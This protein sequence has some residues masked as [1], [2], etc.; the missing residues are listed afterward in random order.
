MAGFAI[1]STA[2]D[3]QRLHSEGNIERAGGIDVREMVRFGDRPLDLVVD[4]RTDR[5]LWFF[6]A[7]RQTTATRTGYFVGE[8]QADGD[9]LFR[10]FAQRL[11]SLH[12][13]GEWTFPRT[14][15]PE[16]K[17]GFE[18]GQL[19]A[20][21]PG[22]AGDDHAQFYTRLEREVA[23]AAE[24]IEIGMG[25][26]PSALQV[27][28]AIA[29]ADIDCTVAVA[30]HGEVTALDG[31]DVLLRPGG[32][33]DFEPHSEAA[34]EI[35]GG[36]A[37]ASSR[38]SGIASGAGGPGS[39]QIRSRNTRTVGLGGL[40]V[41]SVLALAVIAI[42]RPALRAP[43]LVLLTVGGGG[44]VI[45]LTYGVGPDRFTYREET[46]AGLI[47]VMGI[48]VYLG[49]IWTL[50][51]GGAR[52]SLVP[53][54]TLLGAGGAVVIVGADRLAR[55][56]H[57]LGSLLVAGLVVCVLASGVYAM[58]HLLGHISA[59]AAAT[60]ITSALLG[61]IAS[62]GL[63][64]AGR[65]ATTGA[66]TV[67]PGFGATDTRPDGRHRIGAGLIAVAAIG[68]YLAGVAVLLRR[69][70]RVELL[71][72][73]SILGIGGLV[74]VVG[75]DAL[76]RT[77]RAIAAALLGGL[78]LGVLGSSGLV[79]FHLSGHITAGVLA[80]RLV[81]AQLG[82]AACLGSYAALRLGLAGPRAVGSGLRP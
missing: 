31:I 59:G 80:T 11:Q 82:F 5:V 40:V 30:S 23:R 24:P 54:S 37:V 77:R 14:D 78:A 61:L 32:E 29:E 79:L 53:L 44:A 48:G 19:P 58:L 10:D 34:V 74:L 15:E 21:L 72:A 9:D 41:A 75:A 50:V 12:A 6:K 69:G 56:R 64:V 70:V 47:A 81:S 25:D 55:S 66:G 22:L 18:L 26:Y 73:S 27:V 49:G 57:R 20:A 45:A 4:T 35:L 76:A 16:W 39:E 36:Q 7:D 46:V 52:A 62:L 43:L 63:Y 38:A 60:R 42:L 8:Y 33:T 17:A 68:L 28:R 13:D 2:S 51:A 71:P 3:P 1:Y 65:L 67:F